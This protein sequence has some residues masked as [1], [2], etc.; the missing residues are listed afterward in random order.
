M[1]DSTKMMT[2]AGI[3]AIPNEE[4]SARE[5]HGCFKCDGQ[6]KLLSAP[7]SPERKVEKKAKG[8]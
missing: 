3:V 1:N 7:K 6:G 8:K 4:V 5:H 2:P